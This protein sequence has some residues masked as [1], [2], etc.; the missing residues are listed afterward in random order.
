VRPNESD[1]IEVTVSL[2]PYQS[3]KSPIT[4]APPVSEPRPSV[5][6]RALASAPAQLSTK[7]IKGL[8]LASGVV[9]I[10]STVANVVGNPEAVTVIAQVAELI[11]LIG[12]LFGG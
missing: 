8:T 3:H 12:R 7:V 9:G 1:E 11:K 2:P 10:A 5:A 6:A 4:S